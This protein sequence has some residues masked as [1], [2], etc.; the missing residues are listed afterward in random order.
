MYLGD[1]ILKNFIKWTL[2]G[3]QRI[4][5]AYLYKKTTPYIKQIFREEIR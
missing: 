4:G 5:I 2:K 1:I 3:F